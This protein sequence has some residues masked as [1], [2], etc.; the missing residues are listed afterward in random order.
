MTELRHSDFA[1]D[2]KLAMTN[3]DTRKNI[4]CEPNPAA[5]AV[6]TGKNDTVTVSSKPNTV[7]VDTKRTFPMLFTHHQSKL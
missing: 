1:S 5:S 4:A 6:E 2:F 3:V 7:A